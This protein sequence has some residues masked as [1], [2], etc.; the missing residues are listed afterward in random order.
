MKTKF[1]KSSFCFCFL[2]LAS[3]SLISTRPE[4][5]FLPKVWLLSVRIFS[6]LIKTSKASAFKENNL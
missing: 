3:K 2:T 4:A 1:E 5:T 6:E